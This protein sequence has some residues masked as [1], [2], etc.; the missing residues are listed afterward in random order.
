MPDR[1]TKNPPR[2]TFQID[3][4]LDEKLR[5]AVGTKRGKNQSRF[6]REAIEEKLG[7]GRPEPQVELLLD[8]FKRL[9]D[10]GR[11]WLLDA[12]LYA[13]TSDEARQIERRPRKSDG[14]VEEA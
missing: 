1:Q 5:A 3:D 2:I 10:K 9:S 8:R 6:I 13:S 12:A 14:D 4:E 11:Q 7:A